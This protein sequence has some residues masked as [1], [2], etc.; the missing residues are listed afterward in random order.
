[1]NREEIL[2]KRWEEM[3]AYLSNYYLYTPYAHLRDIEEKY[4]FPEGE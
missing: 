2:E 3:K 4:P 1:M